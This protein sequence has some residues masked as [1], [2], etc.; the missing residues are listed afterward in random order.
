MRI[1]TKRLLLVTKIAIVLGACVVLDLSQAQ[2]SPLTS[3]GGIFNN[4]PIPGQTLPS[5]EPYAAI[6]RGK[7]EFSTT[8][9]YLPGPMPLELTRTYRS[10]DTG[11]GGAWQIMPFWDRDE[12]QL[13]SVALVRKH[14]GRRRILQAQE[15]SWLFSLRFLILVSSSQS[16]FLLLFHSSKRY[17]AA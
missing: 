14:S 2:I 16:A 15:T 4:E 5:G 11:G 8:D 12:L 13:R 7:Y 1:G 3:I 9:L 6:S 17:A 10:E